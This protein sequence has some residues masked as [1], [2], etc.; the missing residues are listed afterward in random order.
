MSKQPKEKSMIGI[1]FLLIMFLFYV[2]L[3]FL[4]NTLFYSSLNFFYKIIKQIFWIFFLVFFLMILTNYFFTKERILKY[5]SKGSGRK[6]WFLAIFLGILSAGPIYM[7]YPLL[8]EFKDKGMRMGLI[9]CFLYNRAIKIPL[10]PLMVFYFSLEYALILLIVMIF[11][12]I[13]QG[14]VVE[15]IMGVGK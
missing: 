8:S 10:L 14:I 11:A 4:N 5:F 7:W 1:Y 12:S 6:S 15:K 13:V 2:F 9:S 3:F